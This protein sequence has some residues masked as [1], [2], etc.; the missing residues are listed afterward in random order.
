MAI[1]LTTPQITYGNGNFT[2]DNEGH[3]YASEGELGAGS[4]KIHLGGQGSRSYVY[5]GNKNTLTSTSTGFYLGTDGFAM[6]AGS[7]G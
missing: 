5:S 2:V 4:S 1:D 7:S 6:G 3:L